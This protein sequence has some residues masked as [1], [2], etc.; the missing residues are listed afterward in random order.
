MD[1]VTYNWKWNNQSLMRTIKERYNHLEEEIYA[2]FKTNE[3]FEKKNIDYLE[4]YIGGMCVLYLLLAS[5]LFDYEEYKPLKGKYLELFKEKY[6]SEKFAKYG[7]EQTM[8][9]IDIK[10][11][12]IMRSNTW[13]VVKQD[14]DTFLNENNIK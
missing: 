14:L 11:R 7:K 6:D 13:F 3:F 9:R 1:Q 12:A 8:N 4:F 5:N 10:Y 2:I